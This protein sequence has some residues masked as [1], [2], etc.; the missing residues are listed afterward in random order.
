MSWPT[1]SFVELTRIFSTLRAEST[2]RLTFDAPDA[3]I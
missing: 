1:G 2:R 3:P